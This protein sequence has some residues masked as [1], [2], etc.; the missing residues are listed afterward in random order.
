MRD[1]NIQ[2]RKMSVHSRKSAGERFSDLAA[3]G[4]QIFHADD[5]A[6]IWNIRNKSTLHMT[7]ARY[8]SQGLI[9]RIH[10][11]LY[12]IKNPKDIHPYLLGVKALHGPAY[13]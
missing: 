2:L 4:E 8:A 11:G 3:M 6:N 5:L 9:H 10:K 1:S 13:I 12:S 7:L